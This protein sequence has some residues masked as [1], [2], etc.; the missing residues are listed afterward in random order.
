MALFRLLGYIITDGS[1]AKSTTRDD[2]VTMRVWI[3]TD[4]GKDLDKIF[5]DFNQQSLAQ[6]LRF[7]DDFDIVPLNFKKQVYF[8]S[9]NFLFPTVINGGTDYIERNAMVLVTL[10]EKLNSCK[11]GNN[12]I[13][14]VGFSMGG[15]VA[16]YALAY[17]EQENIPH[18]VDLFVSIDSP[19]QGA[20][21][22][23]GLQDAADLVNDLS[24]GIADNPLDL[25]E[26]P[27]AKQLLKHHINSNS[28]LPAGDPDF[29]DRFFNQLN[30]MGYPQDSRNITVIDGALDG[31]PTNNFGEQYVNLNARAILGILKTDLKLNYSPLPG[32]TINDLYFR[33]YLRFPL[34]KI[35]L[36]KR[37]RSVSSLSALGS[38]ENSPG[39]YYDVDSLADNFLGGSF[40]GIFGNTSGTVLEELL[41]DIF[42]YIDLN[43][44]NPNFSFVP[45]KSSLDFIGNPYLYEDI[46]ARNLTCTGETP[47]DT[48]YA[49][50][51]S[52]EHIFL[53]ADAADFIKDEINGI[54]REPNVKPSPDNLNGPE[55]I[56][57]NSATFNFDACTGSISSWSVSSNLIIENST[58]YSVT[59]K[60]K[61]PT[62]RGEGFITATSITG[63]AST[64]DVYVGKPDASLPQAPI[65]CTN[66]FSEPYTLPNSDGAVSYRLKSNSP[67]L[68][69]N[70][71]SEVTFTSSPT[72]LI[73]FSSSSPGTYL[74]ELFTSNGCAGES[75][76][77]MYITSETC[78]FGGPRGFNVY[79]NPASSEV[80]IEANTDKSNNTT[81]TQSLV[82]SQT[83]QLAKL[84][85]FSG[86]FVKDIELDP[87]G[88]TKMD[89]SNLKE[90][91]YFLK[92]QARVQEET[93]KIIVAH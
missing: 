93:Y 88:T 74:V 14:V 18:N 59:V 19:H 62:S 70:G 86:A 11:T 31:S 20:V 38:L 7:D 77:A 28:V 3:G 57:N 48:Y 83:T 82:F 85:D 9:G 33:L 42:L 68:D 34:L 53:S 24:L 52:Q 56:C 78:G 63:T 89:V 90:G 67:Y 44:T 40:Y 26:S 51:V 60:Q 37:K 13:K 25:L 75:R 58:P 81:E 61:Y 69:I 50:E 16:R 91:L 30:L 43:L 27:A 29:H 15:V 46:S 76:G 71:Q 22:P 54:Q 84:F 39:G 36:F 47:F 4:I 92:I 5:A 12:P 35:T 6:D 1:V 32:N 80:T 10:L 17:M 8:N 21:A 72:S 79:P 65:L 23:K 49:P 55:L 66:S 64:K 41:R 2:R 73:Y 45:S 87:F